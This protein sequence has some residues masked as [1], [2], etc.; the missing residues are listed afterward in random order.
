[1]VVNIVFESGENKKLSFLA[2]AEKIKTCGSLFFRLATIRS[3]GLHR[4]HGLDELDGWVGADYAA[5][6]SREFNEQGDE[7]IWQ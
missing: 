7:E 6:G 1:L 5:R 2:V 3:F 4:L